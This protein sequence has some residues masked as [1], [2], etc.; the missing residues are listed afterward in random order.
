MKYTISQS[1]EL[2]S[3]DPTS[4]L[5]K[6]MQ[7]LLKVKGLH[8]STSRNFAK[9]KMVYTDGTTTIEREGDMI[10]EF[11]YMGVTVK[12]QMEND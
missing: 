11:V 9:G 5:P 2:E 3:R 1:Y 7:A 10:Y 12:E 4:Q 8:P 6:V